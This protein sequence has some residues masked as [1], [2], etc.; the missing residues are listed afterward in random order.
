MVEE[1]K[2]C[3]KSVSSS[4]FKKCMHIMTSD[5]VC[6]LEGSGK[7]IELGDEYMYGRSIYTRGWIR[8]GP[9]YSTTNTVRH[10]TWGPEMGIESV[11]TPVEIGDR[12]LENALTEILHAY[13]ALV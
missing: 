1:E 5:N 8:R 13:S 12:N 6:R 2:R 3:T 11:C 10:A 7:E 9:R 4:R